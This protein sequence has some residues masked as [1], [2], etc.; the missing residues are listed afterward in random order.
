[1]SEELDLNTAVIEEFRANKCEVKGPYENPPPMVLLHTLGAKS[2]KEHIV[3][4]RAMPD[5]ES[6]YVFASAHGSE[7]NP[8]WYHNVI[9]NPD[10]TIEKGIETMPVRATRSRWRGAG[11]CLRPAGCQI[12]GLRGLRAEARADYTRDP[13]R[14]HVVGQV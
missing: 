6:L 4:M 13:P 11:G 9:A 10:T 3:P 1:M 2:G 8:D 14:S 5:G 12:P 7:R